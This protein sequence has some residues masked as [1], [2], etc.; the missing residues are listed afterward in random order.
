M[1]DWSDEA[2][3]MSWAEQQ[4]AKKKL[5]L[6]QQKKEES[7]WSDEGKSKSPK[8]VKK[9]SKPK[10]PVEEVWSDEE[11]AVKP[12][13]PVKKSSKPAPK[14]EES[15]DWSEEEQPKPK[16]K[17]KKPEPVRKSKKEEVWSD[18]EEE[19]EVKPVKKSSKPKQLVEESHVWSDEEEKIKPKKSSKPK[20]VEPEPKKS[21]KPKKPVSDDEVWSDEEPAKPVKKASK[22][23]PEPV[24]KSKKL[25]SDDEVWSED[26]PAPA[27]VVSKKAESKVPAPKPEIKKSVK[28]QVQD[29]GF[30]SDEEE[31]VKKPAKKM[32]PKPVRK[33]ASKPAPKADAGSDSDGS[34]WGSSKED[35]PKKSFKKDFKKKEFKKK[36]S[37]KGSDSDNSNS[38]GGFGGSKGSGSEEERTP[39]TYV[40]DY[41]AADD[42]NLYDETCKKGSEYEA[43][44][45]INI[46]CTGYDSKDKFA[47]VK[48]WADIKD[49]DAELHDTLKK[50]MGWKKPSPIQRYSVPLLLEGRDIMGCAQTGSGKTGGF[51]IP[52]VNRILADCLTEIAESDAGSDAGSDDDRRKACCTPIALV[53]APTRELVQQIQ[54]DFVKLTKDTAIKVEYVVG[55]HAV[56]SQLEKIEGS[57]IIVATPGRLNDFVGKGKIV[58]EK[59][60]FLIVDEADRMLEMGFM[61][62]LQELAARMPDKEDRT[63][64]MFSATFPDEVQKIAHKFLKDNYVFVVVG[65]VGAAATTVTQKFIKIDG[66]VNKEDSLIDL[67]QDV[68]ETGEKTV[69]FV[70]TKRMADFWATKLSTMGFPSTSIHGDREQKERE[71]ALRTFR[72]GEHPILVAT[73]VA[74]RGIDIPEVMHVINHDLPKDLDEYVHRIGR[75]GRCGNKGRATSFY[76]SQYDKEKADRI[77]KILEVSSAV[78]PDWLKDDCEGADGVQPDA[79]GGAGSDA[80]SD[81]GW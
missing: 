52:V 26:E 81:D 59:L 29:D 53:C 21:S 49:L 1:S 50:K 34:A 15:E 80:E 48:N 72:S 24:K 7:D 19:E 64:A 5:Q 12:V 40:P 55:G 33:Q 70:E 32:S 61:T 11:E 73:N 20:V 37:N 17:S 8:P 74:A 43:Y 18:E 45:K 4:K 9:S 6:A 2:P 69:I 36:D 66:D 56:R 35:K 22:P 10:K 71:E 38:D 25:A 30:T 39:V 60:K 65:I 47:G 23:Q 75:T 13:K 14:K 41:D 3:E 58:L 16:A 31:P 67:L 77:C 68:K 46:N 42:D 54:R 78:V 28:K 57:H 62:I 27:K 76:K 63:T 79:A 51:S 44:E